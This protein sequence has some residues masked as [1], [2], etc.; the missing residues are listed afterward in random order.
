MNNG[1][2]IAFKRNQFEVIKVLASKGVDMKA[3][4]MVNYINYIMIKMY[5]HYLIQS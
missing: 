1:L 5:Y 3:K 4:N 2:H